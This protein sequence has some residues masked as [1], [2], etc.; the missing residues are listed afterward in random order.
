MQPAA[1][2]RNFPRDSHQN[3]DYSPPHSDEKAG[4]QQ[5]EDSNSSSDEK[6]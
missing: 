4:A 5:R 2:D 1:P 3:G 6:N